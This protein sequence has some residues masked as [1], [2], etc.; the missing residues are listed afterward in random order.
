VNTSE[1][2]TK[3]ADVIG[4][5]G[6]TKDQLQDRDTG[7]VCLRGAINIALSGSPFN[8]GDDRD[9]TDAIVAVAHTS[10]ILST[11]APFDDLEIYDVVR[12]NNAPDTTADDVILLLRRAA[13]SVRRQS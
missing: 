10:R 2:L 7:A 13:E 8:W 6:L 5:L 9:V 4:Q 3:A 11:F 12:W 1:K